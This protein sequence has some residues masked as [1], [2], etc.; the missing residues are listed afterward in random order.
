MT[1]HPFKKE[2]SY[3]RTAIFSSHKEKCAYCGR[4]IQQRDMHI[5]HIIPS[6]MS[7][8]NDTEVNQYI[9]ELERL[10][11]VRD[12]IENYLPSC[13]ACNLEKSNHVYTVLNLR[14]FHEKA[15]R[16]VGDILNRI[17][18]LRTKGDEYYFEPIDPTVWESLD[19]SYQRDISHAIM[20]YRLTPADVKTCP[21]FPQV[22][23]LTK[24]LALVDYAVLQG[25]TGCGKSISTYQ[26]AYDFYMRG[27]RVYRY[28]PTDG[29]SIPRIPQN[30]EKSLYIIDDA[31]L[32]SNKVIEMLADQARPNRKLIF[33][34]TVTDTISA[35][36]VLLTNRDAVN[37][38]YQDLLNRKDEILPIV[39][40]CDER[41]G[42]HFLDSKIEWR[43]EN[44]K[45][46]TTPWQFN[47][48]L[49]GG[50]QSIKEQ[51]QAI[52]SHHNCGM[53]AAIIAAFQIMQLDNAVDYGQ[54][55]SWLR[56]IDESFNWTDEDLRYL[57]SNK[58]VLSTDDVR[59]LHLEGAKSILTQHYENCNWYNDKLRLI[60]E[61]TFLENRVKPLGLVWLC[62]GMNGRAWRS[63]D[64][65]LI[66]EDMIT[67]ALS[68]L[69]IYTAPDT[70]MEIAYFMEKVFAFDYVKNGHWYFSK[71]KQVILDWIENAS[72]ENAYAYSR[73]INT[74]YNTSK[75]EH[76][77]FVAHVNWQRLFSSLDAEKNPN[78]YSWGELVNRLTAF[79]QRGKELSFSDTLHKTIDALAVNADAKNIMD[80]SEFCSQIAHLSG[81]YIH[82]TVRKLSSIYHDLFLQDM[83]RATN[84]FATDFLSRICGLGFWIARPTKDQKETAMAIVNEIPEQEFAHAL[85]TSYPRDWNTMYRMMC[86]IEKYDKEKAQRIVSLVD[87]Q[88]L[89]DKAADT[90]NT[91]HDIVH[92]CSAL[93]VGGVKTARRFIE[94]NQEK[95]R[96]M[97]SPIVAI[98]PKLT[99]ALFKQGIHVDLMTEHWW[100][101]SYQA[102]CALIRTDSSA[103]KRI[104]K[105]NLPVV[106]ERINEMSTYY[107]ENP[108]CLKFVQKVHD[109]DKSSFDALV[110]Q[111]DLRQ[112]NESWE[113]SYAGAY[114]T[115]RMKP[116]YESLVALLQ[117]EPS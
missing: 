94:S 9:Q 84:L 58:I 56:Q 33:A 4:T 32:L 112:M 100:E 6:N 75:E 86:L 19:F 97:H 41:I 69:D 110:E 30:T 29:I 8:C 73:L 108:Y 60:I 87:L 62:N 44:A 50:W 89:S 102:L 98:A 43:L 39:H 27:W 78:L 45:K 42:I 95:I 2:S 107:M 1:F 105:Q 17:K 12:C 22:E 116:R 67:F 101:C 16:H 113:K 18:I 52:A 106:A 20:G 68:D 35:D 63:I 114:R 91:P 40:Q 38:L 34:K 81:P 104:L 21:R 90:W 37:I 64:P 10:G 74:L 53:L 77:D 36:T 109:F 15:R 26:T 96:V 82:A 31:Q 103:A 72:S 61:K 57:V 7:D 13:P 55:C 49:R 92:L 51:Y 80:L 5:D 24:R 11:F 85:S 115:K 83:P 3:L 76:K 14:S 88:N 59:I 70:R 48:T 93:A 46:A 117:K 54:L 47:Y 25:E 28:K 71:H 66:S 111:V 23:I 65:L 99:V 79:L